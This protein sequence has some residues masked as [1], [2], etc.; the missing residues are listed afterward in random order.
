MQDILLIVFLVVA[1]A[2]V[3]VILLQQ[4][5]GAGMGASFGAGASGTVF[6]SSGSGN[7]LTKITTV[8]AIIFFG[9]AL[10]LGYIA[11][12]TGKVAEKD[13]FDQAEEQTAPV[14]TG[15]PDSDIPVD[16]GN[17]TGDSESDIPVSEAPKS[18]IPAV[19][20]AKQEKKQNSSKDD[21]GDQ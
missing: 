18:D 19:K 6:G 10:T 5:K 14:V 12:G 1:L 3:G 21:S 20:D 11:N 13:L 17:A 7:V 15:N 4:G 2:L 16:A 9:I 8:L